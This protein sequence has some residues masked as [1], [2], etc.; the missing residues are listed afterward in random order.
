MGGLFHTKGQV[1][2]AERP[3]ESEEMEN[4]PGGG[5]SKVGGCLV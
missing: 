4:V 2:K 5:K 1:R 3:E